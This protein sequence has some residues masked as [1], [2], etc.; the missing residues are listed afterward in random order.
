MAGRKS[1]WSLFKKRRRSN[2]KSRIRSSN[3]WLSR[4]TKRKTGSNIYY[5]GGAGGGVWADGTRGGSGLGGGGNGS[6]NGN[7]TPP[8]P[9]TANTGGGGGGSGAQGNNANYSSNTTGGSGIVVIRYA[10]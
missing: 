2:K 7:N 1:K 6:Y 10:T 3:F 5:A 8:N 4:Q 9:G